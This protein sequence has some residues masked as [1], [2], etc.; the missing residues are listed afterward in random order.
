MR[1]NCLAILVVIL[2]LDEKVTCHTTPENEASNSG[3]GIV[4]ID[5]LLGRYSRNSAS[6]DFTEVV[7]YLDSYYEMIKSMQ[8]TA[9]DESENSKL[10][11]FKTKLDEFVIKLNSSNVSTIE[12]ISS[13]QLLKLNTFLVANLDICFK[14]QHH[15]DHGESHSSEANETADLGD[16]SKPGHVRKILADALKI[17]KEG[18]ILYYSVTSQL[19][20][21]FTRK[22]IYVFSI[23]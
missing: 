19:T 9:S 23:C 21:L 13:E 12:S 16:K 22:V 15:H 4:Y 5:H 1:K 8:Y 20:K 2:I 7:S 18:M 14:H 17:P 3:N 10:A 11:C 6:L